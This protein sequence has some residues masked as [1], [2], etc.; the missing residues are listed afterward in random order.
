MNATL[1]AEL[2]AIDTAAQDLLFREARTART[3]LPDPVSDE[4]IE[5]LYELVKYGPSSMNTQ[6]L[7]LVLVRTP[8]AKAR[9]LSH[10]ADGN[11]RKVEQ[12]PLVAIFAADT[13]FNVTLADSDPSAEAMRTR[14][15]NEAMRTRFAREQAWLQAGYFIVG[16]RALGL[17]AGPIGG[18][19]AE[20]VDNDLL[21]GTGLQSLMVVNIG[22]PGENAW[23]ERGARL[24][25]NE[26]VTS[27]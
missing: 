17:H 1:D 26:V 8:E 18:F 21:A 5:A 13:N 10:T 25:Y 24:D 4:Q 22:K 23:H 14:F 20:G 12:A 2:L 27:I 6:P 11:K 15:P 16:I 7:R 3:F 19:D 9:L